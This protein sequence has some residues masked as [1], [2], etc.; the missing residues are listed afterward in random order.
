[1][2]W[3]W[4]SRAYLLQKERESTIAVGPQ[5]F[6]VDDL[7]FW[8]M[9][10][11]ALKTLVNNSVKENFYEKKKINVLTAFFIS[12]KIML[13]LSYNEFLIS[14]LRKLINIF[15][16]KFIFL[17]IKGDDLRWQRTH[18]FDEK[19]A[20]IIGLS[21][22]EQMIWYPTCILFL[23]VVRLTRM[24][25]GEYWIICTIILNIWYS[26]IPYNW[27]SFPINQ[28]HSISW[29]PTLATCGGKK[30]ESNQTVITNQF[31]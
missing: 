11:N 17:L 14:T 19:F 7:K 2:G 30:R 4:P 6:K 8:I 28:N 18:I 26:S 31:A 24:Y 27:C 15:L 9:L 3:Y 23:L 25:G 22:S 13:K 5:E 1:M 21:L 12:L 10:T 29:G 20:L 16:K